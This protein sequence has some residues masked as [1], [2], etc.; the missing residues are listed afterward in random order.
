MGKFYDT[1]RNLFGAKDIDATGTKYTKLTP[2]QTDV[3]EQW[4]KINGKWVD[5]TEQARAQLQAE[6]LERRKNK[7]LSEKLLAFTEHSL[8]AD[9]VFKEFVIRGKQQ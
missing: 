3:I 5:T 1:H 6:I 4:T 9:Q 7:Q 2:G 8:E